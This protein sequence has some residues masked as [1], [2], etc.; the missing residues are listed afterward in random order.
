MGLKKNFIYNTIYQI[1]TLILPMITVPYIS[2][3]LGPEGV[4]VYSY[5]NAY[6]QYFILLGK[7]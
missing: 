1:F 2:R 5:T 6:A 3:V 4:G 7:L